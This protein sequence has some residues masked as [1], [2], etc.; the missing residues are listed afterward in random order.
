MDSYPIK[1]NAKIRYTHEE[2]GL[3]LIHARGKTR[4]LAGELDCQVRTA[5]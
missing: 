3:V 4:A 5:W 2:V 1:Q